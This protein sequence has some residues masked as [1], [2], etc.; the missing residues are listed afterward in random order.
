MSE[1][2]PGRRVSLAP[3]QNEGAVKDIDGVLA[4]AEEAR[5]R[6]ADGVER[7]AELAEEH[8]RRAEAAGDIGRA[9]FERATARK[10][11]E[12]VTRLRSLLVDSH[13]DAA[14]GD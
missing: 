3:G 6:A 2:K 9:A 13:S 7:S 5:R 8:A 12:A 11:R 4:R 1:C 10:A 14:A